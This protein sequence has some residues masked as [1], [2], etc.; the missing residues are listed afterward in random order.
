MGLL[1]GP[2][3][4][5][6]EIGPAP[7]NILESLHTPE[8][9]D[10]LIKSQ[11]G[12]WTIDALNMGIGGPDT[13]VFK[14]MYDYTALVCGAS[15]KGA[16]LLLAGE[17]DVAFNPSG[18]LHHA[19]PA[20]AAGFC[21]INDVAIAC[22]YLASKGKKVLY[23][24]IDV[25]HGDGVQDAFYDSSQVLTISMHE[26]GKVI[27]PGT[28]FEDEIGIGE[29]TGFSVNIP[30]PPETYNDIFMAGFNSVVV[31]LVHKFN[32]DVIVL[33]LGADALAGDPLAHLKL[34]NDVYR[35]ILEFLLA[36][37]KPILMTGGGGYHVENTVR[38][39]SYAWSVI[40]GDHQ[41]AEKMNFGLGGVMLESTDWMGGLQDRELVVT[42]EQKELVDPVVKKTIQKVKDLVFPYHGILKVS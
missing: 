26:T 42:K 9:L 29:G 4:K 24:D 5:V 38:A 41:T 28:G 21:Y 23:L 20:L 36:L 33:E 27:F 11:N 12:N 37:D 6:V 25:H 32:A 16:D 8:Y 35:K 31:P 2:L 1:G 10:A 19:F 3:T 34:T 7:R 40:T 14:G 17:A 18:G 30:F 39:W 13:P 15:I 22:K